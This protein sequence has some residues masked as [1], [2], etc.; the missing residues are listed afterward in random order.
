MM[1]L[2]SQQR[3]R[4]QQ[5]MQQPEHKQIYNERAYRVKPMKG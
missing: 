4:M 1:A 2:K 5:I 3:Q